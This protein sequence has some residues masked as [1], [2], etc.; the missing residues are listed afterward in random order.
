VDAS[1]SIGAVVVAENT[2]TDLRL[3][4]IEQLLMQISDDQRNAELFSDLSTSVPKLQFQSDGRHVWLD[5]DS[6]HEVCA[7]DSTA[8]SGAI[9]TEECTD[10]K[11]PLGDLEGLLLQIANDQDMVEPQSD[12]SAPIPHY[13][14]NQVCFAV[15]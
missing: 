5:V 15:Y 14:L 13:N 8:S 7:A 4:D 6:G 9:V 3:G 12:L 1:S 2:C 10:T 11:L